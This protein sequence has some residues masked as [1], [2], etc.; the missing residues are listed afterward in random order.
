MDECK[1][2]L[3]C[4]CPEC[5]CK[6]TW[7][8]Y[9]CSCRNGLLYMHEHD[10]CIGIIEIPFTSVI[11]QV[12]VGHHAL[13]W[14]LLSIISVFECLSVAL[15][16]HLRNNFILICMDKKSVGNI[17]NTV[18]SW[19]VVKIVILVLAITGIAGY[20]IYKYRIRVLFFIYFF[21]SSLIASLMFTYSC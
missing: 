16:I 17:G 6:N 3:A 14:H 21:C 7:G 8:S 10:T 11:V 5:K 1:E 20:A 9:E 15:Y 13:T 12:V 4:Q 18:T 2:K 19:S